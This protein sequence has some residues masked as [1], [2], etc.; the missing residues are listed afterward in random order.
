MSAPR[1]AFEQVEDG[2]PVQL[3]SPV[4]HVLVADKVVPEWGVTLTWLGIRRRDWKPIRD[5]RE[6]HAIKNAVL[7]EDVEAVELYPSED[8]LRDTS[9]LTQLYA[10]PAGVRF[11]FG[12][13]A[14]LVLT[15]TEATEVYGASG[16]QRP[17]DDATERRSRSRDE[18]T[19]AGAFSGAGRTP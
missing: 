4:Y 15:A 13:T 3:L 2:P 14:R 1:F 18:L 6:R 9:N 10:L 16:C 17:F 8:R 19:A 12:E 11:P 5:W 7:G